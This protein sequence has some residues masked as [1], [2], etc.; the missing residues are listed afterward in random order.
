MDYKSNR[1]LWEKRVNAY[2]DSGMKQMQWCKDNDV[3]LSTLRYWIR[4]LRELGETSEGT[5]WYK[6][7]V[8]QAPPMT[9]V[10]HSIN[11]KV[12]SYSIAVSENFNR[13]VFIDVVR[14]LNE[15][16]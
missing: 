2:Q 14:A 16:C 8:R 13:S 15:L 11:V 4:K 1:E 3:K 10:D 7:D 12:G 9:A 6:L 5:E